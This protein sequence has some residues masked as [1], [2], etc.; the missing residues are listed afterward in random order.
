MSITLADLRL[1][2]RRRA[3][4]ENSR[5]IGVA[6]LDSY[7]NASYAELYDLL[8]SR[9]ADYYVKSETFTLSGSTS[10]NPLPADFY[11]TR[12]VDF[13]VNGGDWVTVRPW[14]FAERN[15]R[16]RSYNRLAYGLNRISYRVFGTNLAFLPERDSSGTF[17]HWY[18]PRFTPLVS[19]GD[20]LIGVMD[21]EEYITVDSAIK[22]IIKQDLDA[23][24]LMVSKAALVKRI[25][26]MAADRDAGEPQRVSDTSLYA[27]YTEDFFPRA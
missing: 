8:V 6:E 19:T 15:A 23:S 17:R 20:V 25:E 3:D 10:N 18:V 27:D 2:V 11:K 1:S 12:G 26:A 22:C 16:S 14:M 13:Q 24:A 21:F 9:F 7:I 4:Q 5:F